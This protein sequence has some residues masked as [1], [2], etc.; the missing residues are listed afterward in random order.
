MFSALRK[1]KDFNIGFFLVIQ[2]YGPQ[3]LKRVL[4]MLRNFMM[5]E[6][7]S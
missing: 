2:S 4:G 5:L 1:Q 7:K 3:W 6:K